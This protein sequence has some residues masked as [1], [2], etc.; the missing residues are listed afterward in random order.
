VPL[1]RDA[2]VFS[3]ES[4]LCWRGTFGGLEAKA[5]SQKPSGLGIII[6][7]PGDSVLS[8]THPDQDRLFKFCEIEWGPKE[9]AT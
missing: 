6:Q 9:A 8:Y 1:P 2:T 5:Y 3:H 7:G 4:A